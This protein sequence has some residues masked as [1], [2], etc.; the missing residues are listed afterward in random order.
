MQ[1]SAAVDTVEFGNFRLNRRSGELRR[2]DHD[3][4]S[5]VVIGRRALGI[6]CVLLDRPG[7]LVAKQEIMDAVWPGLAVEDNNLTV[8]ISALRR[9][10]DRDADRSCIQ[11]DP[12]RG[13]RFVLPVRTLA[14]ST[15]DAADALGQREPMPVAPGPV[16]ARR[17]W[18]GWLAGSAALLAGA[19]GLAAIEWGGR[20]TGGRGQPP[21]MSVAVL[22][23]EAE[24][25]DPVLEHYA[26]AVTE[27]LTTDLASPVS[28]GYFS[29]SLV[30]P[31][32]A[33]VA[34][35]EKHLDAKGIGAAL[36]VR[37][38]LTGR[39]RRVPDKLQVSVELVSTETGALLW[40]ERYEDEPNAALA[41]PQVMARWV[42][43]G[44]V[45]QIFNVEAA[46]S[47]RE[48]PDRPDAMD[49]VLQ[50]KSWEFQAPS[51]QRIVKSRECYERALQ[52]DP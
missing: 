14:D 42:R 37:Y 36:R 5:P 9:I 16:L 31:H 35:S 15:A 41:E 29:P 20:L 40:T 12:G 18:L 38:V 34:Q 45:T 1:A 10:L 39:V 48:R 28:I 32:E 43:P 8:Q 52:V 50:G 30:A 44:M 21:R 22:P 17:N 27:T 47:L 25:G 13:Y 24:K 33:A 3:A 4:S 11:T 51:P 7:R 46:R 23:F 26:D 6:L 2:T 19:G 49:L